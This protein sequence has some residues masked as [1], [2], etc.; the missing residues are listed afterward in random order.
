M[1]EI[2]RGCWTDLDWLKNI[3][4]GSGLGFDGAESTHLADSDGGNSDESEPAVPG[5]QKSRRH[6]AEKPYLQP[7][8][9]T[10]VCRW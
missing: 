5:N 3:G 10:M 1:Q 7:G 9:N 2:K 8:L 6:E 4:E